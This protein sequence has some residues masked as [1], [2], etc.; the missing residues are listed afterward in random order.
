[1]LIAFT[2]LITSVHLYLPNLDIFIQRNRLETYKL[3][4]KKNTSTLNAKLSLSKLKKMHLDCLFFQYC[5][6]LALYYLRQ[7]RN[8]YKFK[9]FF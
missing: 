3:F 7:E 9:S 6:I 1:M 2:C 8:I 4:L 5:L